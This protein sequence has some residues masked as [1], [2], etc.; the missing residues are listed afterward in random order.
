MLDHIRTALQSSDFLNQF[1][2]PKRFVRKR[3]LSMYQVIVYLL[4]SN[5]A[6]MSINLGNIIDDLATL[7]FPS[8]SKQAVS[9]ARQH[10]KPALFKSLFEITVKD[11]Y[12]SV[13]SYN[14]WYGYHLFAIDGSQIHMPKSDS[15]IE[16]FGE[17]NDPRYSRRHYMGLSSILYDVSEDFIVDAE[18]MNCRTNERIPAKHHLE[19]IK[20]LSIDNAL[21]IF[22]RGY[23]SH[24]MFNY[25]ADMGFS[26]LMRIKECMTSFTRC[27]TMDAILNIEAIKHKIRCVR[28]ALDT[29]EIEYLVTN[30]MDTE[31]TA[32]MLKALY[33]KR[34]M[35]ETKYYELKEH[36]G[37][38]KF[39]GATSCAIEQEY[40]IT[41]MKANLCSVI[42]NEAD[43]QIKNRQSNYQA[44]RAHLIGRFCKTFPLFIISQMSKTK[45]EDLF[46][47]GIRN[48]SLIR[49]NRHFKRKMPRNH[50][51]NCKNRKT[52]T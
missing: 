21:I 30:V 28:V 10:I 47:E 45:V 42:K 44:C 22:D 48:K 14:L 24:E 6:S 1:K 43:R 4:Y 20:Q 23:Y 38:E 9:K 33:H 3:L 50:P 5:K 12:H 26:C 11:Y 32:E 37:L 8:I 15:V 49:D 7:D 46:Q 52:T 19:K 41:L 36:W 18:L 16:N 31:I 40:F 27:E 17:Q 2:E 34:W 51:I 29:G 35:I 13:D 25:I 39:N